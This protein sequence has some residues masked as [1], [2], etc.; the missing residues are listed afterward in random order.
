MRL[1]LKD[2]NGSHIL[3]SP[4]S[5]FYFASAIDLDRIRQAYLRRHR[6]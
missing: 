2:Q 1:S 3:P 5:E 6:P 4:L